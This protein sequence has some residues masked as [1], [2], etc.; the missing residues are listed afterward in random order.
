MSR[1]R[2]GMKQL[3][4]V[5]LATTTLATTTL[6]TVLSSEG[7]AN[8]Q[9][10]QV[11]GPLKGAPAVR[12]LKLYREGRFEVAP[13]FTATL[14]DEYNR[15]VL[16]GARLNYGVTD[17]LSVGVWGGF[18]AVQIKTNLTQQIDDN[19]D[20]SA[21]FNKMNVPCPGGD[22]SAKGGSTFTKQVS[23]ISYI[24]TPQITAV[25]FRGKFALFQ[26][27]F[28][29]VDAYIFAGFGI[30]GLKQRKDCPNFQAC[31]LQD[32]TN[33]TESKNKVAPTWGLGFNF[34]VSKMVALGFEW[35]MV[36]FSWN[37]SGFDSRGEGTD[38]KFPDRAVNDDDATYR[39][40]QMMTI[41]LGFSF[42]TLPKITD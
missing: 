37:R 16:V 8:A 11:S 35:R 30:V 40:N 42:P 13:T 36:P 27:V 24:A 32:P 18:G 34:Y 10:I 28:A 33:R 15:T 7:T 38:K 21:G 39:F 29:D 17:W 5:G 26:S 12:R 31:A 22:C 2:I 19:A 1:T 4:L 9:E 3:Y 14:L 25:P 23:E 6:L 41:S 20:R